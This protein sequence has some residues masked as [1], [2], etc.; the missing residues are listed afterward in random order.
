LVYVVIGLAGR[1]V[2]AGLAHGFLKITGKVEHGFG[3]TMHVVCFST[4][5]YILVAVPCA[6]PSCM[7]PVSGIWS[8]VIAIL[9]MIPAQ[10]VNGVRATFSMLIPAVL[11]IGTM[12]GIQ[13]LPA[14]LGPALRP[15][16]NT[17]IKQ[18]VN[19][20]NPADALS[21]DIQMASQ[22]RTLP[23]LAELRKKDAALTIKLPRG[24]D[25]VSNSFETNGVQGW[26]SGPFFVCE[27]DRKYGLDFVVI[28]LAN[29]EI[30]LVHEHP[31]GS[32][33][34]SFSWGDSTYSTSAVLKWIEKFN[35]GQNKLNQVDLP[36]Q[37]VEAWVKSLEVRNTT[38]APSESVEP[39]AKSDT[40]A[41]PDD[42][43]V[44][45]P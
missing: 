18:G 9:M 11:A 33:T 37:E 23:T 26:W 19:N 12:I 38:K 24:L 14:L 34:S 41:T 27:L 6:G 1:F 10:G 44:E 15:T 28:H 8:L 30:T 31:T 3:R 45:A 2:Q 20:P 25:G 35:T 16:G 5:P 40:A 43:S 29:N 32:S 13:F 17:V 7:S 36:M 21:S 4:G 42:T 22:N 39:S